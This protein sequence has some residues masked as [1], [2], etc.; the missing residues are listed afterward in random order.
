MCP[1]WHGRLAL[2]KIFTSICFWISSALQDRRPGDPNSV[3]NG[4]N[5]PVYWLTT[6]CITAYPCINI[7]VN[8][9]LHILHLCSIASG[10]IGAEINCND[11]SLSAADSL[12][13]SQQ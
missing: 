6:N 4:N 10:G 1:G 11:T 3:R 9:S 7:L 2:A 8:G 13:E 12:D 5:Q